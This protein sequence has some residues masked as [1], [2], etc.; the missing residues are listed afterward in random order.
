MLR[1]LALTK[2]Q[3]IL[4]MQ[5]KSALEIGSAV[6]QR[7]VNPFT[8]GIRKDISGKSDFFWDIAKEAGQMKWCLWQWI[9]DRLTGLRKRAFSLHNLGQKSKES[10]LRQPGISRPFERGLKWKERKIFSYIEIYFPWVQAYPV[11]RFYM[12]YILIRSDL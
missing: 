2:S 11:F 5:T 10:S 8:L 7:A 3:R 9:L 4:S 12:L 6:C 1:Q